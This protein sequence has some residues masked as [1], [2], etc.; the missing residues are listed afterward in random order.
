MK[1]RV[2][3]IISSILI[4]SQLSFAG[5]ASA[6]PVSLPKPPDALPGEVDVGAAISPMH[7]GQLAPFTGVLLS[8]RALAQIVA[9]LNSTKDEIKIEV[10][11]ARAEE[12]AT[13]TFQKAE[14]T[15]KFNADKGILQAHVDEQEK[16]I[17]ILN[18]QIKSQ[19]STS[20]H[21]PLWVGLG[22]GVGFV[23][24]AGAAALGAYIVSSAK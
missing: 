12:S 20:D 7:K 2:S 9:T 5:I 16:R 21:V 15:T 23:V 22:A 14:L 19:Q 24:G 1:K 10:E 17:A 18:E 6:D 11:K 8:P 3:C 4:A 13:C